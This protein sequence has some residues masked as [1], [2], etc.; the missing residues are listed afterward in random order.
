MKTNRLGRS[1]RSLV[2][3]AATVLVEEF[4]NPNMLVL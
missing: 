2:R 1:I 3:T 4:N